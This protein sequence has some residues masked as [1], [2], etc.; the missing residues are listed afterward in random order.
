MFSADDPAMPAPT[1]E[2]ERVRSS[3]PSRL[4]VM[5]QAA[6]QPQLVGVAQLRPVPDLD[7][8]AGV[9]GDDARCRRSV[10]GRSV[11]AARAG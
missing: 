9:L 3:S 11:A 10:R 6:E 2:S 7:A 1:G 5:Q 8:L 4:E